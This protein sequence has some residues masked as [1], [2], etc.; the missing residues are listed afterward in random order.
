MKNPNTLIGKRVPRIA[1]VLAL[2]AGAAGVTGACEAD[3]RP[4]PVPPTTSAPPVES[5]PLPSCEVVVE[6]VAGR[7]AT[8]QLAT[9]NIRGQFYM[10]K[11]VDWIH[12][13]GTI[14]TV[15]WQEMREGYEY[16]FP[17]AGDFDV[18][19]VVGFDISEGG[20][21]L[22][23]PLSRGGPVFCDPATVTVAK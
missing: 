6:E 7:M 4:D 21:W 5:V 10:P 1:L 14:G 13:D 22:P 2:G 8:L 9:D 3:D 18:H 15:S 23:I 11:S 19:A 20:E 12:G 16:T 17:R